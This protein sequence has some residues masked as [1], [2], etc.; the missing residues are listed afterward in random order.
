MIHEESILHCNVYSGSVGFLT[1]RSYSKLFGEGATEPS[2]ANDFEP[3]EVAFTDF[4]WARLRGW[5]PLG[6]DVPPTQVLLHASDRQILR[7][8]SG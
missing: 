8:E 5:H 1:H 7:S 2:A 6:A 4:Q 3:W